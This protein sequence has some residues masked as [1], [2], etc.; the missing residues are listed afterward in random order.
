MLPDFIETKKILKDHLRNYLIKRTSHYGV[1]P[2]NIRN[3]PL[4][5]CISYDQTRFD[6]S[7]EIKKLEKLQGRIVLTKEGRD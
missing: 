6:G 4:Y 2:D 7:Q 1:F 3:T 5:E